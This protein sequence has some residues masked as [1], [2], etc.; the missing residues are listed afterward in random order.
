MKKYRVTFFLAAFLL[1]TAFGGHTV[2]AY[3]SPGKPTGFV[4]DFAGVIDATS[5][6]ALEQTL[7]EFKTETTNEIAVVTITTLDGDTLENFSNELFRE[8]GIG[9]KENNNGILLVIVPSD[10]IA[11][12][13]VGY[14]LEGAVPDLLAKNVLDKEIFPSFKEGKYGEG[15]TKGVTALIQASR[16]EYTA[17]PEAQSAKNFDP[18]LIIF[19]VIVFGQVLISI[20]APTKSWWLGGVLGGGA[21]IVLGAVFSSI[22]IGAISLAGLSL[23]GLLIDYV[24]SR[25]YSRKGTNRPPWRGGG[26]FFGGSGGSSS[27][28]GFGGFGGGSSGGGGASSGW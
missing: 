19:L 6:A 28:G 7:T 17:P 24:V 15:I 16:G 18:S 21:G 27:G 4:N 1:L 25:G 10:K 3:Q 14:G 9:G 8:W 22:M 2:L 5:R 20:L 13:E 11:R 26:G 23:L 12:I